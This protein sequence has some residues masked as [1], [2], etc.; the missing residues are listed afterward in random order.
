MPLIGG[1]NLAAGEESA[2]TG[3]VGAE[4]VG[5]GDTGHTA[6]VEPGNDAAGGSGEGAALAVAS[7]SEGAGVESSATAAESRHGAGRLPNI[8][9]ISK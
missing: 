4:A 8:C 2:D 6:A 9:Q 7:G 3:A 5:A 1:R